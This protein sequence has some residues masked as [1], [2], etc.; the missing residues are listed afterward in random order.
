MKEIEKKR[1][2][3]EIII[4]RVEGYSRMGMIMQDLKITG[5]AN[6]KAVYIFIFNNSYK[7]NLKS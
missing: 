1:T 5:S 3:E 6:A 7:V 2:V 4:Q